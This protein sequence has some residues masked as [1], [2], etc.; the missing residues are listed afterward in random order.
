MTGAGWDDDLEATVGTAGDLTSE[1]GQHAGPK[2]WI[3]RGRLHEAKRHRIQRSARRGIDDLAVEHDAAL[4]RNVH[5]LPHGSPWP[6]FGAESCQVRLAAW[7]VNLNG[8]RLARIGVNHKSAGRIGATVSY[9]A[10]TVMVTQHA[11]RGGSNGFAGVRGDDAASDELGRSDHQARLAYAV[12][13]GDLDGQLT[14]GAVVIF[15]NEMDF[16][17]T[18]EADQTKAALRVGGYRRRP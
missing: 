17:A 14:M 3:A 12:L 15:G 2:E 1:T 13:G 18:A 4:Q 9:L 6:G 5:L 16:L 11:D 8:V 7:W 10:F